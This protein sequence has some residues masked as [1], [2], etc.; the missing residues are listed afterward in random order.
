MPTLVCE[1][2]LVDRNCY[3]HPSIYLY[4]VMQIE[5]STAAGIISKGRIQMR[6]CVINGTAAGIM[7]KGRIQMRICVMN[8]TAAGIISKRRIQMRICVMNGTAAGI[9]S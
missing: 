8:G 4:I 9:L 1:K 6:I 3:A 5:I 2:V 7:S